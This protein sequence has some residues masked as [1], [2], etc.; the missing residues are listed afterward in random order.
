MGC[1]GY[2]NKNFPCAPKG[3]KGLK[4]PLREVGLKIPENVWAVSLKGV[5]GNADEMLSSP[6][7]VTEDITA[8]AP[9]PPSQHPASTLSFKPSAL[10]HGNSGCVA[11]AAP[12]L[13]PA[14]P[15]RGVAVTLV[16]LPPNIL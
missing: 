3:V 6:P 1:K 10:D 11:A 12:A 8:H 5:K 14:G 15:P 16:T 7:T 4:I 13:A 9:R 2:S